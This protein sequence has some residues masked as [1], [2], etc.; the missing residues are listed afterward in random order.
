MPNKH[1]A[2]RRHRIL[3]VQYQARNRAEY[4]AGLRRRSR[5]TLLLTL[6]AMACG[7]W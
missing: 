6:E 1:N 4:D 3:K 5:L 2:S 7:W